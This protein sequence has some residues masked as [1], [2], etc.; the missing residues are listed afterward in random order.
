[1]GR[2]KSTEDYNCNLNFLFIFLAKYLNDFDLYNILCFLCTMLC[3][4]VFVLYF[5]K[6]LLQNNEEGGRKI[7]DVQIRDKT[8]TVRV[9]NYFIS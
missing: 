3:I 1:M 9:L 6:K 7:D 4:C 5:V 2:I 8:L